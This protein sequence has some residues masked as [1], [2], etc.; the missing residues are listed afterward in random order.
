MIQ[1]IR[2]LDIPGV[3]MALRTGNGTG[4]LF[5]PI[6]MTGGCPMRMV[7]VG[8]RIWVVRTTQARGLPRVAWSQ[9]LDYGE[10]PR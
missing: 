7:L 9:A 6:G 5:M 8:V 10:A 4:G 2:R 3:H 1:T